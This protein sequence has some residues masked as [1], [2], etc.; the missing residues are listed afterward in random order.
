MVTPSAA[1]TVAADERGEERRPGDLEEL[2]PNRRLGR[3]TLLEL[4]GHGGMGVVYAAYDEELDRKVAVKFLLHA[5]VDPQLR[6]S[7]LGEAK[8]LAQLAHPHVI[9][10]YEVGEAGERVF[11]AM[12]YVRGQ[13]LR[14]WL[15]EP[16]PWP[17]IVE[18]F[19]QA[20]R[21]LAAAHQ[22]GLIHC[23]FK[24]DNALVGHDGRL[25]VLDFGLARR[26][27]PSSPD[28]PAASPPRG[29]T[30]GYMPPEQVEQRAVDAR[31]DQFS[32][33]VALF[34]ALHG[35]RPFAGETAIEMMLAVL[36][37]EVRGAPGEAKI[38]ARLR[39]AIR[40]GLAREPDARFPTMEALLAELSETLPRPRGAWLRIA[41]L[42]AALTSLTWAVFLRSD[43]RP[44][45]CS[46]EIAAEVD[47]LW[48]ARPRAAAERAFLATGLPYAADS[49]ARVTTLL[50]AHVATWAALRQRTCE[51]TDAKAP[52]PLSARCLDRH[53]RALSAWIGVLGEADATVVEQAVAATSELPDPE[54]CVDP[55]ALLTEEAP[56][57]DPARAA[58]IHAI[59]ELLAQARAL[60]L[61]G[62]YERAL[63]PALDAL[64]RAQQLQL[65]RPWAAA[66][67][68]IGLLQEHTGDGARAADSLADAFFMAE[69]AAH[70]VTRAEAAVHLVYV[71]GAPARSP[72]EDA[73]WARL[74]ESAAVG[75]G[76]GALDLRASL[77]QHRSRAALARGDYAGAGADLE[78]A[79]VLERE[80]LGAEHPA[81]AAI[82][83]QLAEAMRLAGRDEEALVHAERSIV[84]AQTTLGPDHPSTARRLLSRAQIHERRGDLEAAL[85]DDLEVIE[86]WRQAYG[87]HPRL[88][89]PLTCAGRV[90]RK[91]GRLDEAMPHYTRALMIAERAYGPTHPEVAR[92]LIERGDLLR[93][94]GRG[95]EALA[96]HQRALA[97]LSGGVADGELWL[98]LGEALL[99]DGAAT[100]ALDAFER[101]EQL[102]P[103]GPSDLRSRASAAVARAQSVAA[104]E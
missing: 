69:A 56:E 40:K 8:A 90:L 9:H 93:A 46:A 33:C 13:T 59:D 35:Q 4:L 65:R 99:A 72:R 89:W 92:A 86:R 12:E 102:A 84:V 77:L 55:L 15:S 58:A 74:A 48:G 80:R 54:P 2:A 97:V 53:R 23:D 7:L 28:D 71:T 17:Q 44:A 11:I 22:A 95:E 70:R 14:R 104:A 16:R 20:G 51:L 68:Q 75:L 21:G 60:G 91:A 29:G 52:E 42:S 103:G 94:R 45:A 61:A 1:S 88:I 101:A 37:G 38:P 87:E 5:G 98:E 81:L 100:A 73:L 47:A 49:L 6:A 57:L 62:Q 39:R 27:A 19:L 78:R 31:S 96:E 41:G 79:L 3:Y 50:D 67:L 36:D 26:Q 64:R 43:D 83:E 85:R 76:E 34:E 63:A 66:S 30:P 18:L 24:P 25:R 10:V 32:F 82:H